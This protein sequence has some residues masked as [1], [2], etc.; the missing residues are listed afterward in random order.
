M[1]N[2]NRKIYLNH[3]N[4]IHSYN[5]FSFPKKGKCFDCKSIIKT[6]WSLQKN[7]KHK[8][9]IENYRERCK[10]CHMKYDKLNNQLKKVVIQ[11]DNIKDLRDELI[12]DLVCQGYTN[13][14]ISR[15]FN[16]N[17]TTIMRI[18]H[19]IPVHLPAIRRTKI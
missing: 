15:I 4:A 7:K 6:D 13:A 14:E 5:R 8:K 10:K 3:V 1:K 12:W 9:G 2:S 18:I 11:S 16:T 17:S 19:K